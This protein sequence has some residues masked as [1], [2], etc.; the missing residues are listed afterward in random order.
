[1]KPYWAVSSFRPALA[2][3]DVRLVAL[4]DVDAI[5]AV[6]A[7]IDTNVGLIALVDVDVV[8]AAPLGAAVDVG[9]VPLVTCRRRV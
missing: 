4:I 1:V 6:L 9:L 2:D 5:L 3:V 8:S 7:G